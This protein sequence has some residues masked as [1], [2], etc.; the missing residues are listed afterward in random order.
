MKADVC[1]WLNYLLTQHSQVGGSSAFALNTSVEA[2]TLGQRTPGWFSGGLLAQDEVI[3]DNITPN[4]YL[5]VSIGGNDIALAPTAATVAS[6]LGMVYL[7]SAEAISEGAAWGSSHLLHLF[8]SQLQS[9]IER[10]VEKQ[11][12]KKVLVCMIYYPDV[13]GEGWA[14]TALSALKYNS[15]PARLQGAISAV[16]EHAVSK[17]KIEGTEV[18]P[19]PLFRVLDGGCSEDYVARVEPSEQGGRKMA[20]AFLQA[21]FGGATA[22]RPASA[23][24]GR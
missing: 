1:Y 23:D 6:M 12:A 5:I 18:V 3:R 11:K 14:D 24:A 19:V 20:E 21:L 9:Y 10:L 15:E 2:T 8:G 22:G 13:N 4:D 7:S 17:I 16:F